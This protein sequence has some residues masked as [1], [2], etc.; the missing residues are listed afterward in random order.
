MNC[1]REDE[2]LDALVRGYVGPELSAHIDQCESCSEIRLIAGGVLDEKSNAVAEAHLPS[3]GTMLWRMQ[4]RQRREAQA[5]ARRSL[6]VGQALTLAVAFAIVVALL[7]SSL[8]AGLTEVFSAIR[9]S[10]PLLAA[11]A[12]SVLLVPI[13]GY[14][15]IRQK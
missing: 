3:S 5:T 2:L 8:A 1:H 6:V 10:T 13:A 9:F 12:T 7:G 15:A 11:L 14:V 4:M